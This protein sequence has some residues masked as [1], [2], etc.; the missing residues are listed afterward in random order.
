[1]HT[2]QHTEPALEKPLPQNVE[3][4]VGVLGSL[5]ISPDALLLVRAFLRPEDFYR[6]AHRVIYQAACDLAD[7]GE[8]CDLITLCDELTRRGQLEP[9]GG[10]ALVSSLANGVP[11]SLNIAHYARIVERCA[12]LRRLIHAAGQIAAVAYNEPDAETARDAAQAL[13]NAVGTRR[14]LGSG[15]WYEQALDSYLDAV[16]SVAE[17]GGQVGVRTGDAHVDDHT[18]GFM[19]GELIYLA[20]RPG[21]GKSTVA[22]TWAHSIAEA[23]AVRGGPGMVEWVT[24]EMRA[25][26]QVKRLLSALAS[27]DGRLMRAGFRNNE[28]QIAKDAYRHVRR[29]AADLKTRLR[30]RIHFSD[31]PIT[32]GEIR[33]LLARQVNEHGCVSA[34]VDYLGLVEPENARA[35]AY[36]RVSD[37]SRRLKQ[38]ALE[39]DIPIFCLLQLNREPERRA[40]KRPM[41]ADLRDSG[42]LEADADWVLG[43]YRGRYYYP[44]YADEDARHGGHFGDLLEM[45]VLKARDGVADNVTVPM[46][47]EGAYT[48]V[49]PWP[50]TGRPYTVGRRMAA[51][52]IS[53][54]MRSPWATTAPERPATTFN[55]SSSTDQ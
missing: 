48:R 40:N 24:L 3:A 43:L 4:E 46:R 54:F 15:Q 17:H 16:L 53:K 11:T 19:P 39:L 18:Q 49:S 14:P 21:S 55:A 50:A 27:V 41:M 47:F 33:D 25:T 29:V 10:A 8:A 35:D 6:E 1:M 37:M 23:C 31:Q 26:Q 22:A 9:V 45:G 36:Q 7:A 28:G 30:H 42:Q 12:T 52:I 20:G 34:V 38:I 51:S 2:A 5:L 44:R 32:I 13:L